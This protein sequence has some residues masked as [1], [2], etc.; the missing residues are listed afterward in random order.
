MNC[1]NRWLIYT[2]C[3]TTTWRHVQLWLTW[4]GINNSCKTQHSST[5]VRRQASEHVTK[6]AIYNVQREYI[7]YN[8]ASI[9]RPC[10]GTVSHVFWIIY[11]TVRVW[12]FITPWNP[13]L[14][15]YTGLRT[16]PEKNCENK[17]DILQKDNLKYVYYKEI[18]TTRHKRRKSVINRNHHGM[19]DK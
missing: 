5:Y 4:T 2:R 10:L 1:L 15:Q 19:S 9:I 18:R 8:F 13:C 6:C 12:M 17:H 7:T 11:E 14:R 16:V 3:C